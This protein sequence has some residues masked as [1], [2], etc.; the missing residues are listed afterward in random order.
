MQ[1]A[2]SK[3]YDVAASGCNGAANAQ[4]CSMDSSLNSAA[5]AGNGLGPTVSQVPSKNLNN[6]KR[7]IFLKKK[8]QKQ[9]GQNTESYNDDEKEA[10]PWYCEN[11]RVKYDHFDDHVVSNRHRNFACD[12]SNFKEI[13]ELIGTLRES[14]WSGLIASNGESL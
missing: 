2:A 11:C 5:T 3:D 8:Q 6:L 13:D 4:L 10:R 14:R 12:D 9:Q 7:R 1:P